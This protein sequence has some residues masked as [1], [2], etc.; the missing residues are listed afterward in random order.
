[1]VK[2]NFVDEIPQWIISSN[3]AAYQ[4]AEKTIWVRNNLGIRTIP[5]LFHEFLHYLIHILFNNNEKYH[6]FIDGKR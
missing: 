4:P 6:N 1:M 3:I 2:I 5:V